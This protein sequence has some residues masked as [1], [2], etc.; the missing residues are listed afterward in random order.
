[1][2][3]RSGTPTSF[4]E[5]VGSGEMTV[6]AEKLTRFPDSEPRKRPSFPFQP[7]A[8]GLERAA[9][10]VARRRRPAD[11]VVDERGDVVLEQF[12]EVL[13]DQ[14]RGTCL[15]VLHE[16]LVDPDDVDQLVREVV[17]GALAVVERDGR[18]GGGD[19]RDRKHRQ[20]HPPGRECSESMPSTS[21]SSSGMS[22]NQ[23]RMSRG[24]QLVHV[25]LGEVDVERLLNGAA[26]LLART[27]LAGH[28][29]LDP[30]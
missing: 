7:L 20:D 2:A 21:R 4:S 22:S 1:M 24:H 8:E 28:D 13:D 19:R 25:L 30:L 26:V 29:L 10:A 12:P 15:A 9:G 5:S 23:S 6:R 18:S 16:P 3:T 27:E 11:L 17:L 14:L